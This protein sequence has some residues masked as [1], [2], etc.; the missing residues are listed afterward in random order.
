MA[1]RMNVVLA[2]ASTTAVIVVVVIF[3]ILYVALS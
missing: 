2:N 3:L 1:P